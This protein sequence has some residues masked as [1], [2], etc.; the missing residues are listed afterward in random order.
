[1]IQYLPIKPVKRGFKVFA[2]CGAVTS[3]L[4][5]FEVYT[6]QEDAAGGLAHNEVMRLC[7]PLITFY[8][9]SQLATSLISNIT[10]LVG[11]IRS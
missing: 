7:E 10:H 3:I 6:G 5:N 4:C 2:S 1:M 8:T 11:T 9:S